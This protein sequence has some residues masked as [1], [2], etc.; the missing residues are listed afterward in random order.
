MRSELG[1]TPV[2]QLVLDEYV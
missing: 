1:W 2:M